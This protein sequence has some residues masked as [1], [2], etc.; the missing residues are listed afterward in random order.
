M[1]R[2]G[3]VVI[4]ILSSI[5]A[6]LWF[7]PDDTSLSMAQE[8]ELF[9]DYIAEQV[10]LRIYDNE[11]YL[12]DHMQASGLEH[13]EQLGFT[14]FEQPRYTLFNEQ[15]MAAWEISSRFAVWFPED[16]I[17][18]EQD[19]AIRNLLPGELVDRIDSVELTILLPEKTV[20][21]HE[22]VSIEGE[23][24]IIKGIGLQ[25]NLEQKT[26]QLTTHLET[27]YHNEN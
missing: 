18:L 19:V 9:P 6:W 25:A 4:A 7:A 27:R 1:N 12:A 5:A 15:H 2:L 24:F 8:N 17:M 20:Q 26:L 22:A 3:I 13:F 21:T 14:Q 16:K 10:V 11:G 23:G